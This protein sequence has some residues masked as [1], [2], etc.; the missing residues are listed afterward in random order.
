MGPKGPHST[1]GCP[2]R[3]SALLCPLHRSP[4]FKPL[5]ALSPL[6]I[7]QNQYGSDWGSRDPRRLSDLIRTLA[8]M[9]ELKWIRLLY[10]YPSYFSD[11]CARAPSAPSAPCSSQP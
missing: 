3:P 7:R 5:A 2:P 9:P 11:E 10:C 8:A 4:L 1:A 6:L